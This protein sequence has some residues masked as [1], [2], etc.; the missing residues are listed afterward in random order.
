MAAMAAKTPDESCD[1]SGDAGCIKAQRCKTSTLREFLRIMAED[2]QSVMMCSRVR[3]VAPDTV[4]S[5]D[6]WGVLGT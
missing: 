3:N 4:K 2:G 6:P 5:H 1:T